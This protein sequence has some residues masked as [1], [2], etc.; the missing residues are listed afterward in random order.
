MNVYITRQAIPSEKYVSAEVMVVS[1]S[2]VTNMAFRSRKRLLLLYSLPVSPFLSPAVMGPNC[3][4]V[5]VREIYAEGSQISVCVGVCTLEGALGL[6]AWLKWSWLG[7]TQQ[8]VPK[9]R[10]RK[11]ERARERARN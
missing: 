2:S 4:R 11:R 6:L 1:T 8:Q 10:E 5:C 7:Q 9:N 3:W